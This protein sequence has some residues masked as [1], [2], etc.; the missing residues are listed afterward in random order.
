VQA[1]NHRFATRRKARRVHVWRIGTRYMVE[2]TV[3]ALP[4]GYRAISIFDSAWVY[5]G[6]YASN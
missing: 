1:L 3:D 4:M 6:G 5:R 2:D